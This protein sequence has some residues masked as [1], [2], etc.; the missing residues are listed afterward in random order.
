MKNPAERIFPHK[1]Q[2]ENTNAGWDWKISAHSSNINIIFTH[3]CWLFHIFTLH[4]FFL[5]HSV[6]HLKM[7]QHLRPFRNRAGCSA[8]G[9]KKSRRRL[10]SICCKTLQVITKAIVNRGLGGQKCS[11]TG[12]KDRKRSQNVNNFQLDCAVTVVCNGVASSISRWHRC[13]WLSQVFPALEIQW[14]CFSTGSSHSYI[15][16]DIKAGGSE[17]CNW[18]HSYAVNSPG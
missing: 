18:L 9:Y 15:E 16:P 10:H 2:T 12:L 5:F 11:M 6:F 7:M 13:W 3:F 8:F 14:M 4:C 17:V 1:R